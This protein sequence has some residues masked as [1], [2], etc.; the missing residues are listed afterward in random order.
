M[1]A[2]SSKTLNNTP[3]LSGRS[4]VATNYPIMAF[5]LKN[6]VPLYLFCRYFQN[7][8]MLDMFAEV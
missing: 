5:M 2:T 7:R 3:T 1:L 4:G 6:L 8:P